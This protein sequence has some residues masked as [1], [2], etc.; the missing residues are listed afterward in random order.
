[1]VKRL[2]MYLILAQVREN[3]LDTI[4]SDYHNVR[5]I[6]TLGI[7]LSSRDKNILDQSDRLILTQRRLVGV[8]LIFLAYLM[9]K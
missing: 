4:L 5:A 8:F 1:M 7:S 3:L 2:L 9:G 6:S